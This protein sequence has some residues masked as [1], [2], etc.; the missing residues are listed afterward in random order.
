[1]RKVAGGAHP[2]PSL[3]CPSE[4]DA[5]ARDDGFFQ[6]TTEPLLQE[7]SSRQQRGILDAREAAVTDREVVIIA[8]EVEA[9]KIASDIRTERE[10][11]ELLQEVLHTQKVELE[12][13]EAAGSRREAAHQA[14]VDAADALLRERRDKQEVQNKR[15][16]ADALL[17]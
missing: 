4:E 11:L 7:D 6:R 17:K 5:V 15:T 16:L 2:T 8:R 14:N 3:G 13:R 9:E 10:R 1:M 12:G